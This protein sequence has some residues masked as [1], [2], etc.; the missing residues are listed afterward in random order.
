MAKAL[1]L[2]L[3]LAATLAT[4]GAALPGFA[5]AVGLTATTLSLISVGLAISA[6]VAGLIFA[7]S[8]VKP[9]MQDGSQTVKQDIAPR[10]R[11]YGIYRLGGTYI[12]YNSTE[13]GDL[14]VA[15]DHVD[16][17]ID[18]VLE[19][20]LNDDI[21]NIDGS[22]GV[23]TGSYQLLGTS[24]VFI[25]NKLG[26]PTQTGI[27]INTDWTAVSHPG[28]G[29]TYTYLKYSD[30]SAED[31]QRIYPAGV[32][33][34]FA[35]MRLAKIYDPRD[36]TQTYGVE[37]SY[38]WS[39]NA[40]LVVLDY[41]TRTEP[42]DFGPIPVGFGFDI[43]TI[44][45][46]S[47]IQAA[48]DCDD[49]ITLKAGG[50]E[51]RYRTW[52]AFDMD[53]KRSQILED[54]LT[55]CAG[56]LVYGPDG[57]VG[58]SVG[59]PGPVAT[60]TINQTNI[61]SLQLKAG[62]DM[63]DRVNEVRATYVSR[64]QQWGQTEA[65][66]Q[67]DEDAATRNG[68][69]S[70]SLQLRFS[71]AEGQTQRIA[72]IAL[73]RSNP[74]FS[75]TVS[76]DLALLDCWGERWV[77]LVF[78]EIPQFSGLYE[79][80]AQELMR[81][82]D[83][84]GVQL[85]VTSYDNW[86]DWDAATNEQD[87][88]VPADPDTVSTVVPVPTGVAVSIESRQVS[89][90]TFVPIGNIS[91]TAPVDTKLTASVRYRILTTG[92]WQELPV[93]KA[94][95]SVSTPPLKDNT[96]YEAQVRFFGA[97]NS[98]SDWTAS[99][100]FTAIANPTAPP[101]PTGL[102]AVVDDPNDAINLSVVA[103]NSSFSAGIRFYRNSTNTPG[104][105][106][107]VTSGS[108]ILAGPNQVVTFID[109]PPP[110]D[111][112]YFAT[113]ENFS[114]IKSAKTAGVLAELPPNA[115]SFTV[116]PGSL[117]TNDN[118]PVFSGTSPS[119]LATIKL[120]A[121]AVQVGSGTADGSG[122]WSFAPTTALSNGVN[123][124]TATA[125]IA[126]N[127]SVASGLRAVTVATLDT[128][129]RTLI[130]AMVPRPDSTRQGLLSS[131]FVSLKASTAWAKLDRL[132][133][134]G[135]SSQA[136]CLNW[137]NPAVGALVPTNSPVFTADRGFKGT[138]LGS[139]TGGYLASTFTPSTAGGNWTQD[140]AHLGVYVRTACSSTTSAQSAEIGV[141]SGPAAYIFTK[142]ATAGNISTALDDATIS[143]TAGGTPNGIGHFCTSRTAS[144]GYAK[145]H[146]A[147]AQASA[148]ITSTGLP[149]STVSILRATTATYSDAEIFAAHWGGG[150][151]ATEVSDI[152]TALHTFGVAIGAL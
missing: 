2:V 37:T 85:T 19:H 152:R 91:W 96:N 33:T 128:D 21:V 61:W 75:G 63:I 62:S 117:S 39:D 34:Y 99:V 127:E 69:E 41:L 28:K 49:D 3:G 88:A 151:T 30:G 47:F 35:T 9:K 135:G 57:R 20:W 84:L 36:V 111:W 77:N 43:A 132:Y 119:P 14:K 147:V 94:S 89:G 11:G 53:E 64:D 112:W 107:E 100:P 130:D 60:V 150:L 144:T 51:K 110:G 73:L 15:I 104:T 13:D 103:P 101:L 50:A 4:G 134:I 58:L 148:T 23:T 42:S 143:S 32:P 29:I 142:H 116:P 90:G 66:I 46:A 139:T 140:S 149:T 44:N 105:A 81:D 68:P 121:N 71:P 114:G 125:T 109:H 54:M 10:T 55:N 92:V 18:S 115:P 72:R 79:I 138:A 95:N 98:Y 131:A 67:S 16:H 65:G 124:M 136:S 93:N 120:Y 126:G 145:Y 38:K 118:K 25:Q 17:E 27:D 133:T 1:P 123:N 22:G 76:G 97:R 6:T 83:K 56:R 108:G 146:E 122:N 86:F 24:Y 8:Q 113:S 48:N 102:T 40:A 26:S 78:T 106:T 129:A 141:S 5:V 7:P 70:T 31:Q 82:D 87:P 137:K 52:G 74:S 45:I 12:Y 80:T 59:K